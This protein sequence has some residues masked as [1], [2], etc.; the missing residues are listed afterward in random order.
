MTTILRGRAATPIR[1]GFVVKS[2]L[3]GQISLATGET[4]SEAAITDLH[5]AYKEAVRREN[6]LREKKDRLRGMTYR[7]F[8]TLFKFAQL[9]NLVELVREESMQFP[10]PGDPLLSFRKPDG[11]HFIP[12]VR[13]VFKLTAI[14]AQDELSWSNLCKAWREGWAAP[15]KVEYVPPP[16]PPIRPPKEVVKPEERVPVTGFT[17][18][19]WVTRPTVK[20]FRRLLGHLELLNELGIDAPGIE[21]EVDHL[22]MRIGDWILVI[23]DELEDAGSI[24]STAAI[25]KFE[26]QL[27]HINVVSEALASKNL[28]MAIENLRR[29]II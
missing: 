3:L 17:P 8:V 20:E 16:P 14:G 26:K 5:S 1:P 18:Y 28:S 22:A 2:V 12:S 24:D 23:E 27:G 21:F 19:K 10:P 25:A 11:I 7:S 4:V 15:Q 29:L 13:R 6:T 9:L